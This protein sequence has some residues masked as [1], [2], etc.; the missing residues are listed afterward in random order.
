MSLFVFSTMAAAG[1]S[2]DP[3]DAFAG[4]DVV[5]DAVPKLR[6]IVE[7][8]WR[9]VPDPQIV[10]EQE[11]GIRYGYRISACAV[12]K[13]ENRK[14]TIITGE[15]ATMADLGHEMRHCF[16]GAWHSRNIEVDSRAQR[17]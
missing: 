16:Q 11:S 10:C 3:N 12:R 17:R 4:P 1:G 15:Q 9:T 7:I 6:D 14:C 5:F 8:R 13:D 2:Q